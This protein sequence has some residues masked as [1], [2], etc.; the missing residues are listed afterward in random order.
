[1]RRPTHVL[2][3]PGAKELLGQA[4]T[5]VDLQET[6][7]PLVRNEVIRWAVRVLNLLKYD[8]TF[9]DDQSSL[10]VYLPAAARSKLQELEE[11]SGNAYRPFHPFQ[12]LILIHAA[13]RYATGVG[14]DLSPAERIGRWALASIQ[15]NDHLLKEDAKR[16]RLTTADKSLYLFSEDS[17]RWELINPSHPAI[18]LARTRALLVNLPREYPEYEQTAARL[19]AGFTERLGLDFET[20]YSITAFAIFWWHGHR[21]SLIADPDAALINRS[22]W[23]AGGSIAREVLERYVDRVGISMDEIV[24]AFDRYGGEATLFRDI[25]PFRARPLLKLGADGLAYLSPQFL[26]EKGGVDLFWLLADDPG[27][28]QQQRPWTDDYSLLFEGYVRSILLGLSPEATGGR[29]VST[30]KWEGAKPGELDGAI[31]SG[32]TLVL[33]ETKASL[34]SQRILARGELTAVQRELQRKFVVGEGRKAKGLRQLARTIDWLA[35]ERYRGRSVED[36][37]LR[38]ITRIIPVLIVADRALLFPGLGRWFQRE[39]KRLLRPSWCR[40]GPV[41]ICGIE[42]LEGLEHRALA[43]HGTLFSAFDRY[44]RE[45]PRSEAPLRHVYQREPGPHPRLDRVLDSWMEG[46]HTEGVLPP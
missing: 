7:R 23:L 21:E 45:V 15:I 44:D 10:L 6:L 14:K 9:E 29:Y 30:L 22:T 40:V 2:V 12:Q 42:D 34:L 36:I 39:M 27:G 35:G 11:R 46:L 32:K 26:A 19:R 4:S 16:S 3:A 43:G 28:A 20:A 37:D 5:L 41:T 8:Q 25:L 17:P 13:A 24:E 1:M 18:A 33:L 31:V 38:Q